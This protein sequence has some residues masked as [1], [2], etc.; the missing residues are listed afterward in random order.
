MDRVAADARNDVGSEALVAAFLSIPNGLQSTWNES[1]RNQY[2]AH[3]QYLFLS[4]FFSL[5]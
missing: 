4:V 3:L 1:G 5:A 2:D